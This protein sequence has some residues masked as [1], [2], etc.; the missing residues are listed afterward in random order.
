MFT[1]LVV[2]VRHSRSPLYLFGGSVGLDVAGDD[3]VHDGRAVSDQEAGK[4]QHH[5]GQQQ[6]VLQDA[7]EVDHHG[8][9]QAHALL[10]QHR[11]AAQDL[12]QR[13]GAVPGA[14]DQRGHRGQQDVPNDETELPQHGAVERRGFV[15]EHIGVLK[16]LAHGAPAVLGEVHNR[17]GKQQDQRVGQQQCGLHSDEHELC[18]TPKRGL[19]L[20]IDRPRGWG[21]AWR[22]LAQRTGRRD[23]L[24]VRHLQVLNVLDS[25]TSLYLLIQTCTVWLPCGRGGKRAARAVHVTGRGGGA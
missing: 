6:R 7:G 2:S 18:Q 25:R 20:L 1:C 19:F 11:D 24:L 15:Q 14:E 9:V 22:D 4:Q 13:G 3:V 8:Q 5:R 16:N 17:H 10:L 12:P 23:L 21:K